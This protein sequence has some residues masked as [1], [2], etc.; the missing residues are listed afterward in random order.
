MNKKLYCTQKP[1]L[2]K[3][4]EE[5]SL[6]CVFT[7]LLKP[8][9][10]KYMIISIPNTFR[11]DFYDV[12]YFLKRTLQVIFLLKVSYKNTKRLRKNGRGLKNILVVYIGKY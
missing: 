4:W 5:R 2:R 6:S 3:C 9:L 7:A 12:G 11:I 1:R 10:L 8:F